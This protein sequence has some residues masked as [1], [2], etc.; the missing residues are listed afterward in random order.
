MLFELTLVIAS[1]NSLSSREMDYL[2]RIG[3]KLGFEKEMVQAAMRWAH[4]G[5]LWRI[6]LKHLLKMGSEL[7]TEYE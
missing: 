6:K 7:E 2:F 3:K 1:D 5:I 4:E